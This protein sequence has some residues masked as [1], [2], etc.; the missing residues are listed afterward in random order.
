M[1]LYLQNLIKSHNKINVNKSTKINDTVLHQ[2]SDEDE[3]Y[4]VNAT[5]LHQICHLSGGI[6]FR[7]VLHLLV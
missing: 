5:R 3:G 6:M 2:R 1:S 4:Y 7:S